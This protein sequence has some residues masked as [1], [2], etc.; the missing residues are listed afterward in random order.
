MTEILTYK[1]LLEFVAWIR[2]F[3]LLLDYS[4]FVSSGLVNPIFAGGG[5]EVKIV[6]SPGSIVHFL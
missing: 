6:Y 4:E 1:V 2:W 5:G 3:A